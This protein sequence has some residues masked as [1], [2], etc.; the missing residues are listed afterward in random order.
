MNYRHAFQAGNFA[1]VLKH[2]VITLCVAHLKA[3]PKP[4][5]VIDTHGG[6]GWYD[7]TGD[8]A[9]RSP[10]WG[11]GVGRLW[12][13]RDALAD[14]P[15]LGPYLAAV[16]ACNPDGVLRCYPGS[17]AL[18]ANALRAH[19]TLRLCELH[20]IDAGALVDAFRTDDRVKVEAR[21][22]YAALK[23]YLP[24]PE[25]RGLVIIDPPFEARDEF[26]RCAEAM[27]AAV[28]RWPT[29]TY[30]VWRPLKHLDAADQFDAQMST[31]ATDL[32]GPERGLRCDLWVDQLGVPGPLAGAGVLVLNPPYTLQA[33]LS[34][35]L[36]AWVRR[37]GRSAQAGA[38]C[39][40]LAQGRQ[41][42]ARQPAVRQG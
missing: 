38:R 37:L 4:F 20:P 12:A 1:D 27:R 6:R 23:A 25:R 40:P 9:L 33:T 16:S 22:G 30:V 15:A 3:K 19:D 39:H 13:D 26:D 10:E 8:E 14:D 24:P 2:A 21:D 41:A 42:R 28:K 35:A 34:A 29:G 36:P 7:L 11:A 5:R 17:P 18:V 32:G 31:L